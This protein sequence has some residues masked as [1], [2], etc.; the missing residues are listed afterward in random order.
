MQFKLI[1]GSSDIHFERDESRSVVFIFKET[2]VEDGKIIVWKLF[3]EIIQDRYKQ[4]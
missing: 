1:K 3:K 2:R 4:G